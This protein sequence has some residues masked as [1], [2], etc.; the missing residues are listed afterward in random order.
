MTSQQRIVLA[1]LGGALCLIGAS[2]SFIEDAS[3]WV[4]VV[5]IVAMLTGAV[6]VGISIGTQITHV[7]K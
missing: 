7:K 3:S 1:P 5:S 6:M 4:L 2:L